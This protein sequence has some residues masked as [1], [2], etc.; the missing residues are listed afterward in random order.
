L[1][2]GDPAPF[3]KTVGMRVKLAMNEWAASLA[4]RVEVLGKI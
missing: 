1:E 2:C 3:F 4:G